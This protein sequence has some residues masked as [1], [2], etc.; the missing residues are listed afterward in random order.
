MKTSLA[1]R[2]YRRR[3]AIIQDYARTSGGMI[4]GA[5]ARAASEPSRGFRGAEDR[6]LRNFGETTAGRVIVDRA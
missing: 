5:R 1:P 2:D 6:W 3:R 4:T